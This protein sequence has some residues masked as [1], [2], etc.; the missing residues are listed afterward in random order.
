MVAEEVRG[1]S[2]P[3]V[4]FIMAILGREEV[5]SPF[6]SGLAVT[7]LTEAVYRSAAMNGKPVEVVA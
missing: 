6:E 1:G 5:Q 4:N 2:T 3:D 7:R